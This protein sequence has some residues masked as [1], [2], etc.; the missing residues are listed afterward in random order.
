MKDKYLKIKK[1]IMP[2]I[3]MYYMDPNR[4]KVTENHKQIT[5]IWELNM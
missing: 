5:D 1:K 2:D 4:I 3:K